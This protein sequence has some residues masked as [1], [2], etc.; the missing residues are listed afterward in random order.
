MIINSGLLK[1]DNHN[2]ATILFAFQRHVASWLNSHAGAHADGKICLGVESLA[3]CQDLCI[4]IVTKVN[5]RVHEIAS[6]VIAYPTCLMI[7]DG[8]GCAGTIVTHVLLIAS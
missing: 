6:T 1:I 7:M 4:K 8:L 2:L 5:D 3:P